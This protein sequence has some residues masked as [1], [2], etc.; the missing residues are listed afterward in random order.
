MDAGSKLVDAEVDSSEGC[1]GGSSSSGFVGGIENPLVGPPLET[2][3]P[4]WAH[5]QEEEHYPMPG[6]PDY[7]LPAFLKRLQLARTPPPPR[8][9]LAAVTMLLFGKALLIAALIEEAYNTADAGPGLEFALLLVGLMSE[10]LINHMRTKEYA[11]VRALLPL[12]LSSL[13]AR[14]VRFVDAATNNTTQ[15]R[16]PYHYS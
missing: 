1:S 14:C 6:E 13:C 2:S 16:P 8:T 12:L 15:R 7:G 4:H 9:A 10:S 11:F 5:Q 3:R